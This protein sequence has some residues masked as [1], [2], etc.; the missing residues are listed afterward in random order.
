MGKKKKK[1]DMGIRDANFTG[2]KPYLSLFMVALFP[3]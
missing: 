3:L 1:I 2:V